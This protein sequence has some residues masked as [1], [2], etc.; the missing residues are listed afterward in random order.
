VQQ[1]VSSAENGRRILLHADEEDV[2][3]FASHL[4]SIA[5]MDPVVQYEVVVG[6]VL[7]KG[8]K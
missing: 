6:A 1:V 4:E 8:N 2:E 3:A 5:M 7:G